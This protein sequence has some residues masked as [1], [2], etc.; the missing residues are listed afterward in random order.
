MFIKLNLGVKIKL[1]FIK[2][3]YYSYILSIKI[4]NSN[5]STLKNITSGTHCLNSFLIYFKN[6]LSM[7]QRL[8]YFLTIC[9]R[10]FVNYNFS[11]KLNIKIISLHYVCSYRSRLLH[12]KIRPSWN[13]DTIRNQ[14]LYVLTTLPIIN[15]SIF[16]IFSTTLNV[17]CNR[18][19][20]PSY[21]WISWDV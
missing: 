13:R 5:L 4:F 8:H 19:K 20:N 10:S 7:W 17:G 9:K 21:K 18:W 14:K 15:G 6:K 11:L 12:N 1:K 16:R 2:V 3:I